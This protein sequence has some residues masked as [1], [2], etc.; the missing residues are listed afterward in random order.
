MR[1]FIHRDSNVFVREH[2][3]PDRPVDRDDL[4]ALAECFRAGVEFEEGLTSAQL[5]R[6]LRPWAEI[7][8]RAAWINFDAWQENAT[9]P[10]LRIVE[11]Q[12]PSADDR[13]EPE[14]GAVVIHPVF[15]VHRVRSKKSP[16][17]TFK[18]I[19][20]TSGRYA[21]PQPNGFGGEDKY[22]SLSFAPPES[23]AHLPLI[24]DPTLVIDDVDAFS[25]ALIDVSKTARDVLQAEPVFFDSIVL[26]FLD[27]VSFHGTPAEIADAR[28]ELWE[29]V[30]QLNPANNEQDLEEGAP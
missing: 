15:V 19:W 29:R 30:D 20:H 12:P 14:L 6:A 22:C 3:E 8:S 16:S 26:G 23:W 13:D 5:F 25:Q 18:I 7:L 24:I 28:K 1:L 2:G 10:A 17:I 4:L 9:R 27:D 21:V 11:A